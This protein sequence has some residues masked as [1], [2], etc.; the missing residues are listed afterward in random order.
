MH[1][2]K[3]IE[4]EEPYV[5]KEE[6]ER[7][8][9]EGKKMVCRIFFRS[10]LRSVWFQKAKLWVKVLRSLLKISRLSHAGSLPIVFVFYI[11]PKRGIRAVIPLQDCLQDLGYLSQFIVITWLL[12]VDEGDQRWNLGGHSSQYEDFSIENRGKDREYG[13]PCII[14]LLPEHKTEEKVRIPFSGPPER[15]TALRTSWFHLG[16]DASWM[17]DLQKYNIINV[18]FQSTLLVVVC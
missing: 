18:L 3:Q 11:T 15:N 7:W 5:W 16:K 10:I 2:R 13:W 14:I 12:K 17:A 9:K 4:P 8:G 6:E 1:P